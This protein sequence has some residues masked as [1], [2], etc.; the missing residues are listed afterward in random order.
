MARCYV[1]G[2][3]PS[4]AYYYSGGY[5][6]GVTGD[7]AKDY[8][9]YMSQD[10]VEMTHLL[11]HDGYGYAPYGAYSPAA[12]ESSTLSK[13]EA[14]VKGASNPNMSNY[15]EFLATARTKLCLFLP[16]PV[17]A[18][19]RPEYHVAEEIKWYNINTTAKASTY[20]KKRS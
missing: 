13:D 9:R 16:C 8:S 19:Y 3:Y 1:P 6:N 20:F 12:V 4:A 11:Y 10:G 14:E 5:E 17:L 2:A 15:Q 7:W 18:P